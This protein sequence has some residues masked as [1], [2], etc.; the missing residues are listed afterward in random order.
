MFDAPSVQAILNESKVTVPLFV[1]VILRGT[2]IVPVPNSMKVFRTLERFPLVG[3]DSTMNVAVYDMFRADC[4]MVP[5]PMLRA[6][7]S[8]VPHAVW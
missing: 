7:G 6:T 3:L 2:S 4:V 5:A 8:I 1:E